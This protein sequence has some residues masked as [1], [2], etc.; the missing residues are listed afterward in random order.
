[1]FLLAPLVVVP[2]TPSLVPSVPDS[3]LFGISE[4]VIRYLLLPSAMATT[5]SLL[6]QLVA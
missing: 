2:L 5:A 6:L 4:A 1:V 3:P